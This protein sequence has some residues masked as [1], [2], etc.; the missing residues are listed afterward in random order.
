MAAVEISCTSIRAYAWSVVI[1]QPG[2][3]HFL[4]SNFAD[5]KN[6]QFTIRNL[7]TYLVDNSDRD[8]SEGQEKS[9]VGDRNGGR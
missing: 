6:V 3:K 2:Y 1:F 8:R 7:S 4:M 5:G 9:M